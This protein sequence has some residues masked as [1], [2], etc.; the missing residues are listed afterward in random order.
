MSAVGDE[1]EI[2]AKYLL[3]CRMSF[4]GFGTLG[5]FLVIALLFF[6]PVEDGELPV[7]ARYPFDTAEQPGHSV[8]YFVE[9]CTVSVGI[10]A[11]IGVDS[12]H[13]NL[14]NLFLAQ[15]EILN[16][17][18]RKCGDRRD[19][20]AVGDVRDDLGRDS[21]YAIPFAA[22]IGYGKDNCDP[23]AIRRGGSDGAFAERL[24]RS[25]RNHQ[26]LL[27]TMDNFN[28]VF[29]AGMFVQMLSSTSMICLTGFQA[30][31]VSRDKSKCCGQIVIESRFVSSRS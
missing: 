9:A 21:R 12:L 16:V 5:F 22:E 14:C 30:T 31:L 29:S 18:F 10:T 24:R 17:H 4:Y 15:L 7:R 19:A 11:I 23:G 6:V 28:E 2:L 1:E 3:I 26:R 27:A 13:T 8:G 20:S 25:V